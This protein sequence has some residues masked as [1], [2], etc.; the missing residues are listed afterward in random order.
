MTNFYTRWK[1]RLLTAAMLFTLCF[2]TAQAQ[3]AELT[4]LDDQVNF[5]VNALLNGKLYTWG[6][7]SSNQYLLGGRSLDI[8]NGTSWSTVAP[9]NEPKTGGYG[10]AI[11]GKIYLMGGSYQAVQN[12]QQV[13]VPTPQ[14]YEY[15]PATNTMTSK[16][17][18][19][20]WWYNGAGAVVE[21][22]IYLMGG[23]TVANNSL[24]Y[25]TTV[26]VYDPQTNTW[27]TAGNGPYIA[28]YP[29]ATAIG[30]TIYLVGG[31]DNQSSGV[32]AAYKGV[33]SGGTI[34]WTAIAN[35]PL[36]AQ[37]AG[38]GVLNGKVYVAGGANGQGEL[39]AVYK[40][41]PTT[42]KWS[43][44][45][46]LPVK[47]YNVSVM[48]SDASSLYWIGGL[49]NSKVFQFTPGAQVAIASVEQT[50][51]MVTVNKGDSKTI[52]VPVTNRGVIDL[53]GSATGAMPWLTA[54][55]P[56]T[57]APGATNNL[58]L[59]VNSSTLSAGK[60]QTT[61]TLTTNDN[62][63]KTITINVTAWVVENLKTQPFTAVIEEGG[64]SWCGPCY[65]GIL[66]LQDIEQQLGERVLIL[67]YHGN[68]GGSSTNKDPMHFPDGINTL[69][70]LG[71]SGFPNA[72]FHRRVF[73]GEQYPMIGLG[74]WADALNT[75]FAERDVAAAA[76]D[77]DESSYDAATK[78][79]TAKVTVT[80]AEAIEM[81]AGRTLR[82]T[83]L[84]TQDNIVYHQ[85]ASGVRTWNFQDAVRSMGPGIDGTQLTVPSGMLVEGNILPPGSVLKGEVSFKVTNEN[86]Q[87]KLSGDE[88]YPEIT[89]DA[90]N[91]LPIKFDES[92]LVILAHINDGNNYGEI[93]QGVKTSFPT[94]GPAGPIISQTTS[95][96]QATIK[97]TETA[98]YTTTIK[99][100]T[101]APQELTV[102]RTQ[103]NIPSG[104]SS[105]MKLGSTQLDPNTPSGNVTLPPG[106]SIAVQL[107]VNGAT[108]KTNGTVTLQFQSGATT[109]D[110]N[111]ITTTSES[112]PSTGVNDEP[113]TGVG[114][115]L[116]ANLP[117]PA[118]T[119]TTFTYSLLQG[120]EVTV[121]VTGI[122]GEKVMTLTPG[123]AEAGLHTF[124]L[125]VST[126]P[127]GSYIVTLNSN[128]RSVSRRMT[129][130]H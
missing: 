29:T 39:D 87:G 2:G 82:L 26:H 69:Q 40:Y 3:W 75:L 89:F 122:N 20:Q 1:S 35:H 25:N 127:A 9:M 54:P 105:Y 48:P 65:S 74:S 123:F 13:I 76:I 51:F 104:W 30:N 81:K 119:T 66:A 50:N 60:H 84:V 34:T 64:G 56:L 118:T 117:N 80:T 108:E 31:V 38:S 126:L 102:T 120:G 11:N 41:D 68:Q 5:A 36:G 53:T 59:S 7:V 91:K 128:G 45:Y 52:R 85:A 98:S 125:D 95:K 18:G 97:P 43:A 33:V 110:Q 99:N 73:K 61:A 17:Q 107:Y 44:D 10:A 96:W 111:Y 113:T 22:K 94:G 63:N 86:D 6:G 88:N 92:H 121:N 67:S 42:D 4:A 62:K 46:A 21:G 90:N 112:E 71:L 16:T 27:S 77:I 129:V 114:M 93:L 101:D 28:Q 47:T 78:M 14:V 32:T 116:S 12:G 58:V 124:R 130:V 57:V 24:V 23:L 100:L 83:G 109:L 72:A 55:Q 106:A 115:S 37:R 79:V 19:P 70:K 103:N 8:T 49:N 15:D